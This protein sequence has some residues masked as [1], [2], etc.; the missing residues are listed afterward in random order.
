MDLYV[1]AVKTANPGLQ[2]GFAFS[3]VDIQKSSGGKGT[4]DEQC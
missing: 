1:K 3:G 4:N 2:V